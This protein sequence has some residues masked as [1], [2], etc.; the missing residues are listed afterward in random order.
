MKIAIAGCA[1]RMGQTL[2]RKVL[3]T[4]GTELSGGSERTGHKLEG[5]EVGSLISIPTPGI[6]ITTNPEELFLNSDAVIDFTTPDYSM[7][8]A[9]LAAKHKKIH[10]CGTTAIKEDSIIAMKKHAGEAR[11]VCSSNMSIGVNIL[12][13]LVEKISAILG[14]E[15]C[16]IE[17]DEM[18]HRF[19][20]DSPSGTALT[21][22]EAAARG[23]KVELSDVMSSYQPGVLGARKQG[24]IGFSVRRGGDVIGDHTVTFACQGER[25]EVA[26]K[27]SSREIYATGAIRAALWASKQPA[28]FYTMKDV[29][30]I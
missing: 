6:I 4:Q 22:G 30:G 20:V 10:I 1:G 5:Q 8:L 29:L 7:Q 9:E 16:D 18:H 19:K 23:R 21:L 11:I 27:A 26:H 25:I 2:V 12:L 13:G 15:E 24:A 14:P 3:A 28:G 17:V